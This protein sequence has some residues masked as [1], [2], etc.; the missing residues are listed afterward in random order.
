MNT[1][2][3]KTALLAALAVASTALAEDMQVAQLHI[4]QLRSMSLNDV[5]EV[6]ISTGTSKFLHQAPAVGYV[7]TAEDIA[8]L[9]ARS[10]V[11]VLESIP[12]L[13]VYLYQGSVNSPMVDMRG[14]FTNTSG[15][16]LFL[17]D[18]KPL[19][20]LSNTTMP[21]IFRLP[22][23]FV[24]RVEVVRGPVSAV[25]GA[26]ALTGVVNIIT[27]KQP[28][29]AGASVGTG[30]RR[31]AWIGRHGAAGPVEWSAAASYSRNAEDM[32]TRNVALNRSFTQQFEHEYGD[33][34]LKLRA[35]PWS[36]NLWALNYGK[37]ERGNLANPRPQVSVDTQNRHYD[38]GY[39]TDLGQT[40]QLKATLAHTRFDALVQGELRQGRPADFNGGEERTTADITL[41]ETRFAAHRLRV[42]AGITRERL[43]VSARAGLGLPPPGPRSNRYLSVQDEYAFAP[44]WE[45]TAAVRADHYSTIGTVE[46]PR[47]GLV[48]NVSPRL[49]AKLLHGEAFRAPPLGPAQAVAAPPRPEQLRN[50]ELAFDYRPNERWHVL[51]NVYTYRAR[52]LAEQGPPGTP[53]VSRNGEG[54]ELE[55]SWLANAALRF[56]TSVSYASVTDRRTGARVPYTPRTSAKFA[57]NW[58][59]AERWSSNLRW[60]AYWDRLRPANDRRPPLEDFKLVHASVRYAVTP[61]STLMLSAHNLLDS[62]AYLPVLGSG[63]TEDFQLIGRSL[64]IHLEHRF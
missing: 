50:T 3:K 64:S 28:D 22:V 57:V 26:D 29:E 10:M 20:L 19:R 1:M 40:T 47:L 34:D 54:T 14:S 37:L 2:R 62:R 24:E 35:G 55:M 16:L 63:N 7:V 56:N 43:Q 18:G 27:R 9:G 60:E 61:Q 44:D 21:E 4:A 11:E 13:N 39:G 49:T 31:S 25:Y 48:W 8:R 23:H 30:D 46:N 17:R 59:T 38:V 32:V 5:L 42:N 12:G 15:H 53:A 58:N 52:N 36:A 45:L 51:W 6:D 33:I 41:T